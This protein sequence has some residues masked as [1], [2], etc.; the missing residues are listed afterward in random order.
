MQ[1]E[2]NKEW[3]SCGYRRLGG[4][5][6]VQEIDDYRSQEDSL[7]LH[8]LAA[9]LIGTWGCT[10]QATSGRSSFNLTVRQVAAT[11]FGLQ[12]TGV[13]PL[14]IGQ[15]H[16]LTRSSSG[17]WI[18][19]EGL[20]PYPYSGRQAADGSITFA[21]QAPSLDRL[22]WDLSTDGN[23]LIFGQYKSTD[24]STER[25]E[26]MVTCGRTSSSA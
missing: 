16:T 20:V 4:M 21:R 15:Y 26:R 13:F 17:T 25:A 3:Y 9:T 1:R 23:T 8:L 5:S 6:H 14:G 12:G 11:T 19:D 10:P 2:I 7:V 18:I 24:F 22:Y